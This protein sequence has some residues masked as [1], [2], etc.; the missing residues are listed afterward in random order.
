M[1]PHIISAFSSSL[2]LLLLFVNLPCFIFLNLAHEMVKFRRKF[3]FIVKL[4]SAYQ[5]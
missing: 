4:V 1:P 3:L 5:T 2:N